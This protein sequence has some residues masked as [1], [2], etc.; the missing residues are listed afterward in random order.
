MVTAAKEGQGQGNDALFSLFVFLFRDIQSVRSHP[1]DR[2]L[3]RRGWSRFWGRIFF[4]KEKEKNRQRRT[5]RSLFHSLPSPPAP[6]VKNR[7]L[8]PFFSLFLSLF[9]RRKK[10]ASMMRLATGGSALPAACRACPQQLQQARRGAPMQPSTSSP[11]SSPQAAAP[12]SSPNPSSRWQGTL[13][14]KFPAR[15]E[16]SEESSR[17]ITSISLQQSNAKERRHFDSRHLGIVSGGPDSQIGKKTRSTLF[18]Q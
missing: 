3:L 14:F 17:Y 1:V 16:S 6:A 5:S 11:L 7:H 4:L 10:M 12:R 2:L 8:A 18:S 13:I 15:C 9:V